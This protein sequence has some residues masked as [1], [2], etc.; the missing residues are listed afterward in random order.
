MYTQ[1]YI[2]YIIGDLDLFPVKI[3]IVI[4]RYSL[5]LH[6]YPMMGNIFICSTAQLNSEVKGY[7]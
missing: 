2:K 6:V 5:Q 7:I 4:I 3:F 1:R